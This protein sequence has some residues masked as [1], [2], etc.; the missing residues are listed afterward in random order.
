MS[1]VSG[2]DTGLKKIAESL[3]TVDEDKNVKNLFEVWRLRLK[4]FMH[5]H[6]LG[7]FYQMVLLLLSVL[8]VFQYIYGSYLIF[9]PGHRINV[10]QYIMANI[11]LVF[12]SIFGFDWLLNLFLADDRLEFLTSF[13]SMIDLFTVIPTVVTYERECPAFHKDMTFNEIVY[14]TLCGMLTTRILRALRI[15]ARFWLIEDEVQRALANM[16]LNIAVMI[17]YNAALM[18]YFEP[19]QKLEF[20]TW[21][22]YMFVTATTVGY[23]DIT[24]K[25][26][27]GRFAAMGM[28]GFAIIT[29]PDMTNQLL[30][31]MASQSIYARTRYVAKTGRAQHVL[32]CGDIQHSSLLEFFQELFHEDHEMDNLHAVVLHPGLPN[33]EMQMILK[34]PRYSLSVTYLEGSP[35]K[36][37]DLNRAQAE[38]TKAVFLLTNKFSAIPDEED[39]KIIL[40][41]FSIQRYLRL[42][43]ASYRR[44]LFCLQL[45][46]PE[47]KRHL[48]TASVVGG[49]VAGAGHQNLIV[50]L[51]EIKMGVIAKGIIFPGTNTLIMNLLSSFADDASPSN[52]QAVSLTSPVSL[53]ASANNAQF[54]A[55]YRYQQQ[56]NITFFTN[57]C[58]MMGFQDDYALQQQH[59]LGGIETLEED[60][61]ASDWIGEYQRGCDWEIYTTEL[62]PSFSGA[63]FAN[64]SEV[65]Y[66]KLGIVLFGLEIE[67]LSGGGSGGVGGGLK[68]SGNGPKLL[69]NPADLVIPT[70]E[71]AHVTAFVIAKNKAQSDLS[72]SANDGTNDGDTHFSHLSVLAGSLGNNAINS[73]NDNKHSSTSSDRPVSSSPQR[74]SVPTSSTGRTGSIFHNATGSHSGGG[75]GLFPTTTSFNRRESSHGE[76]VKDDSHHGS[77]HDSSKT[78]GKNGGRPEKMAWQALLHRHEVEKSAETLQEELQKAE[79]LFIKEMYYCHTDYVMDLGDVIVKTSIT[80]AKPFIDNHIIIIGKALSNLYD[81]IR[82]LRAKTLGA[83]KHIVILYPGDFPLAVWQRIGIFESIWIVRGSPLEEA[84]IRRCGIFKAK[85]VIMLADATSLTSGKGSDAGDNRRASSK[86]VSTTDADSDALVDADA[87]FCYQAVKRLN[88]AA[89]VVVEIVRQSNVTYLDPETGLNSNE[90]D[91]KFTPQ[92]ASGALFTTSLLDT[93]VCQAFYNTKIVE[94]INKFVGFGVE[95]SH[96]AL[97]KANASSPTKSQSYMSGPTNGR[98]SPLGSIS[99]TIGSGGG[100]GSSPHHPSSTS[101][102]TTKHLTSAALYQIPV[103]VEGLESRTY[104]ALYSHL[105]RRNLIPLGILRGIFANT[106]S[107]PKNNK[108]PYVFTNPPKDTELFS[109][110]KVF[111]LSQKPV[112]IVKGKDPETAPSNGRATTA[113]IIEQTL[114]RQRQKTTEDVVAMLSALTEDLQRHGDA[115]KQYMDNSMYQLSDHLQGQLQQLA[116]QLDATTHTTQLLA[117]Q[118]HYLTQQMLANN[119]MAGYHHNNN[120]SGDGSRG[121]S[122][123]NGLQATSNNV[124]PSF[125]ANNSSNGNNNVNGGGSASNTN[126][127]RPSVLMMSPPSSG[128]NNATTPAGFTRSRSVSMSANSNNN[129]SGLY[130]S[131]LIPPPISLPATPNLAA[132][133]HNNRKSMTPNGLLARPSSAASTGALGSSSGNK[134]LRV[135]ATI[136]PQRTTR[137]K[138]PANHISLS[139]GSTGSQNNSP[140]IREAHRNTGGSLGSSHSSHSHH[141]SSTNTNANANTRGAVPSSNNSATSSPSHRQNAT[142]ASTS[143]NRPRLN[144]TG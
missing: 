82:P 20:H 98:T 17:L 55:Q 79:D 29:V 22:Y 135:G 33:A 21:M 37:K 134:A 97:H 129:S 137:A 109:C 139:G 50:C 80:E 61:D 23:G 118:V 142:A 116:G 90:I 26:V 81:L 136:S 115:Q 65:L 52:G 39:A 114:L 132:A 128:A 131:P 144:T 123:A 66:L 36:D 68:G 45:I 105:A 30:E 88:E 138:S 51:N 25:S 49:A 38:R 43:S 87:I 14:Y 112:K 41:Q 106:K 75:L 70:R 93:L 95:N 63:V 44:S 127:R 85:Q 100:S 10:V 62:S 74:I 117:Q 40:Q 47:N 53:A 78:K 12:A 34:D 69:L 140:S 143:S 111:V 121:V 5:H 72:F 46:R 54:Y 3:D 32:I 71:E 64:L 6:Y 130:G 59:Y 99:R 11:E 122:F 119:T 120:N 124:Y 67:E 113:N 24:P 16:G 60:E 8:S 1:Q 103:M 56:Q 76:E 102:F 57:C 84:D 9:Y 83:L 125:G 7:G 110:D 31:K 13:Y 2:L 96:D 28:I 77:P 107:G 92:F 4:A 101:A 42:Y 58:R 18:Q 94:V 27:L 91:Y 126:S 133:H 104:G 73:S 35:L 48:A 108:M 15:R 86:G 89:N 19:D 141:S